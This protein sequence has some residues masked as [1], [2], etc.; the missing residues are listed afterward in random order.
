MLDAFGRDWHFVDAVWVFVLT[1]VSITGAEHAVRFALFAFIYLYVWLV[2]R[3][4]VTN[5]PKAGHTVKRAVK[6]CSVE[7]A[8]HP[9]A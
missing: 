8:P 2:L 4:G 3:D 5:A 6:Q 9:V 7:S 1:A